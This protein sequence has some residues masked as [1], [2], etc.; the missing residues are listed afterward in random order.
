[1]DF[2]TYREQIDPAWVTVD[3]ISIRAVAQKHNVHRRMVRQALMSPEPPD[4]VV[5]RWRSHKIDPFVDAIDQ[6]LR[7]DFDAPRKQR[8]TVTRISDRLIGEHD[9]GGLHVS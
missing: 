6:M 9:A 5:R 2:K 7:S 4:L 8:H 1:M 3:G